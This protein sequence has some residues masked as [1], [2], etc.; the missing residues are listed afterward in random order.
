MPHILIDIRVKPEALHR[1]EAL[2]GARVTCVG[3]HCEPHELP[4][5]LIRDVDALVCLLPPQNFTEMR[6]L[7][8][9]QLSSAGF[10]Q[11]YKLDL[12]RRGV[13][14]CNARGVYDT[15]IAEWS[16]AMMV[17][18]GRDLRG[19]IR[20]QERGHWERAPRFASEIRGSVLGIWGYGGIGRETARLAKALGLTVHALTRRGIGPRDNL[21]RVPGTGDSDGKLPDRVFTAG[22]EEK[23]LR[24]LDFLVLAM[25]HT[26]ANTGIIG[27]RELH[28]LKPTAFLLNPARGALVREAA[29][30]RALEERWFAGAALDTHFHYPMP[31][32]HPL[33][34]M[35]N[36]ILTPHISGSDMGPHF[37]DRMWDIVLHNVKNI[38][39]GKPLWN[40]LT[41][42]E[43]NERKP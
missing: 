1:L 42:D 26:P 37:L 31:P 8:F 13:R 9:I 4:A 28:A 35:P 14:A 39:A 21:Y 38:F 20:N 40:E 5:E 10:A 17:N 15:A 29:L 2:P 34:R 41:A 18:L 7:K 19:M 22:Q 23:F 12:M 3:P 32:A 24:G 43:L 30:V 33:W 25:P 16:I 11:L 36:V 27:E 6:T